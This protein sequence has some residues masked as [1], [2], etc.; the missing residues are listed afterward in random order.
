MKKFLIS[1]AKDSYRREL[2]FAQPNTD[3]VTLFSA[4]NM[5]D[6]TE[7]DFSALF[8]VDKFQQRYGRAVTRG[9]I[10]C[11]LSHLQVYEKLANDPAIQDNEFVLIC[12]DDALFVENY[13]FVL[14]QLLQ[15]SLNAEIILVGQSKIAQFDD[16]ELEINYPTTFQ[17]LRKPI[18]HT[19]YHYALPY[20]NYFAGTVTYLIRKSAVNKF[21]MQLK[22]GL[23][24][25]LADDYV[26]FAEALQIETLVIR[27][28]LAIENPLLESNLSGARKD[29]ANNLAKKLVKYPLKKLM[30]IQRNLGMK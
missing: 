11:T 26:L 4:V 12:E 14:D 22:E 27:P 13:Q 7:Q 16:L 21:L 8:D 30:A 19:N 20:K 3:D 9:E 10:G 6:K 24:Y 23:P 1:L 17:A 5:L 25:W 29:L 28:L 15:Q 18:A 2:F